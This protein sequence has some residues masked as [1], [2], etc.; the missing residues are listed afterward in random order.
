MKCV[1]TMGPETI[2]DHGLKP[3]KPWAKRKLRSFN[4]LFLFFWWTRVWT[5]GFVFTKQ[6]L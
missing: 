4:Y 1:L 2:P 3:L 5:Q 6:V